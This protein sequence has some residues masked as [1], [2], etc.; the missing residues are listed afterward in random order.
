[1]RK[2]EYKYINDR[3]QEGLKNNDSKPFWRYIKARKQDNIGVSPLKETLTSDSLQKANILLQQ[4]QSVFTKEQVNETLPDAES[5]IIQHPLKNII[6]DTNGVTKL[7]KN[8]NTS[9]ANG[10]DA[11]P[12]SILKGCAEQLSSGLS[13]VFQLSLDSGSRL[14]FPAYT[15]KGTSTWL[16]TTARSH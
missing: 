15:K 9:K 11:I 7:L 6:M 1:M 3:I 4:F 12:N 10:P 13:A 16:K 8:L 2:A 5:N 14:I